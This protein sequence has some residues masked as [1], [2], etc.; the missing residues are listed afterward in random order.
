MNFLTKTSLLFLIFSKS[1]ICAEIGPFHNK[2]KFPATNEYDDL[3]LFQ[4]GFLLDDEETMNEKLSNPSTI[5]EFGS[6]THTG[7]PKDIIPAVNPEDDPSKYY[8]AFHQVIF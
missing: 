8:L 7:I 6:S 1:S 5:K 4:D 2:E 3:E